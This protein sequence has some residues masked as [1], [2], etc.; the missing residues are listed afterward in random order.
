MPDVEIILR[1]RPSDQN[2]LKMLE[3]PLGFFE[4]FAQSQNIQMQFELITEGILIFCKTCS[5]MERVLQ[6]IGDFP[7]ENNPNYTPSKDF[8]RWEC[9]PIR[10]TNEKKEH[11]LKILAEKIHAFLKPIGSAELQGDHM[12]INLPNNFFLDKYFKPQNFPKKVLNH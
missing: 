2:A 5:D 8:I 9:T 3:Y 6:F 10:P 11:V 12:I 7:I 1:L 4:K